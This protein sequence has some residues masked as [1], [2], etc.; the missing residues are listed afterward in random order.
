MG[1]YKYVEN[2]IFRQLV[3]KRTTLLLYSKV[4]T[5]TCLLHLH[6]VIVGDS[7]HSPR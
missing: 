4:S 7:S 2:Y 3:V 6:T 1:N 5:G